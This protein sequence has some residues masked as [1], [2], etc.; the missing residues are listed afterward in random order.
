MEAA[1]T[2]SILGVVA[3]LLM[4]ASMSA[5][6]GRYWTMVQNMG[7]AYLTFESAWAQRITFDELR[8]GDSPWPVHPT[9]SSEDV[10]IGRLPGGTPV[11]ATVVRTRVPH[12][13]NLPG[14]GGTGDDVTN[15]AGMESWQLQSHLT[16]S[17]PQRT[18][19][20]SRTTLR[21]R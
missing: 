2:I 18:Y 15:P 6:S 3:L 9:T 14:A 11:T 12:A 17:T 13:N 21:T 19:S 8:A 1:L 20:K 10:E 5:L 7:D 16:Y 4:Q